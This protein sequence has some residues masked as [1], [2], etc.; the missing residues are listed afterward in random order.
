MHEVA[1]V[2]RLKVR[3]SDGFFVPFRESLFNHS[4][5]NMLQGESGL[6][7]SA[8]RQVIIDFIIRSRIRD[9]GAQ[10]GEQSPLGSHITTHLPLHMHSR[11]EAL[12]YCWVAYW[13]AENWINRNGDSMSVEK[14]CITETPTKD[15]KMKSAMNMP[16]SSKVPHVIAR[17]FY[18][19]L[20]QPL[21]SIEEYFG[22]SIGEP[23]GFE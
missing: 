20:H 6:F 21:D 3:K 22:E 14:L 9:S 4:D 13:R 12:Y 17:L 18:G 1:E 10:L 8:M 19:A 7:R 2:L 15:K 16:K 11:L 23:S 5:M